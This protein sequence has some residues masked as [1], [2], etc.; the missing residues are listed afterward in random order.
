M[1]YSGVKCL[2]DIPEHWKV[3]K[4]KYIAIIKMGQSPSSNEYNYKGEGDP[5]IQG[6]AEFGKLNPLPKI[7]CK[8][9]N[10]YIEPGDILLS[11]RAPVGALNI[12]D[13]SYGIGR[14]LCAI[15]TRPKKILSNYTRY[16]LMIVT[17]ELY[18]LAT[19]STYDAVSVG[20]VA[21]LRCILPPISEQKAIANF[22]DDKLTQIDEYIAE[23][24][25]MIKLLKELKTVIIN[26]AVTKGI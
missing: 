10:K 16:L 25:R 18:K 14:G 24:Q 22:L 8:T 1:K 7:Y 6:S 4:L 15:K 11:V 9:A 20:E 23:A 2:G 19:G 5:F 13:Q 21:N 3:K 17:Q 12:A 26:Q